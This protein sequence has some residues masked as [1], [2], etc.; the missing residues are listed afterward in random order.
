MHAFHSKPCATGVPRTC[1]RW[2]RAL[3]APIVAFALLGTATADEPGDESGDA[4]VIGLWGDLPYSAAQSAVGVPNLIADMN[5]PRPEVH[6]ARWRPES[7][8]HTVQ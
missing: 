5:A 6:G 1:R 2:A 7:R 8:R 4:Y 3:L